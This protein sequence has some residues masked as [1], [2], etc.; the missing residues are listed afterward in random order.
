ML[1]S[2]RMGIVLVAA[3]VLLV[4]PLC[5]AVEP[6]PVAIKE[7]R[8]DRTDALSRWH[9][10]EADDAR[11]KDGGQVKFV[12]RFAKGDA[13]IRLISPPWMTVAFLHKPAP[14]E[15]QN[16]T[17]QT[18]AFHCDTRP[19]DL[20]DVGYATFTGKIVMKQPDPAAGES[21]DERVPE[22]RIELLETAP[23]RC[24][25]PPDELQKQAVAEV[26]RAEA[27]LRALCD[28]HQLEYA[29]DAKALS[30]SWYQ[31]CIAFTSTVSKAPIYTRQPVPY[32]TISVL[33]NP[34]TGKAT[35][36]IFMHRIRQ[37]PR[38]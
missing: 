8:V 37:D 21:F 15:T 2:S 7:L 25:T 35:R 6:P 12:G 4:A 11:A 3:A 32:A 1:V 5:R 18:F 36:L 17:V 29:F 20:D 23:I 16:R 14:H 19:R 22:F 13:Q 9:L 24:V 10:Y 31:G 33:F 30:S 28:K 27:R 26:A 34:E 38:D